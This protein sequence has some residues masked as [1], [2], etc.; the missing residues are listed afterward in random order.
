MGFLRIPLI[1]VYVVAISATYPTYTIKTPLEIIGSY[2]SWGGR[3]PIQ[4]PS[5]LFPKRNPLLRSVLSRHKTHPYL[6]FNTLSMTSRTPVRIYGK[7]WP[8][9]IIHPR[10]EPPFISRFHMGLYETIR[11]LFYFSN[12]LNIFQSV[13][14]NIQNENKVPF[15]W[16]MNY[17]W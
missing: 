3:N 5:G 16:L 11:T 10:P 7:P 6:P 15:R 17:T 12:L 2:L 8:Y 4:T 14:S 1:G 13:P 9:T